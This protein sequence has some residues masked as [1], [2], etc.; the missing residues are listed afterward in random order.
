MEGFRVMRMID[1]VRESDVV[2]TTTGGLNVVGAAHLD[3]IKDQCILS[4]VGHFNKEIDIPALRAAAAA[5]RVVRPDVEEFTLPGGRRVYLLANGELV[6]IAVGQGHPAEIMDMTFA[7]QSLAPNYL[8]ARR[9]TLEPRFYPMPRELD[10][11]VAQ[12]KLDTLGIRI[13]ELTDEQKRYSDYY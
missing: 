5:A 12:M 11:Q 3:A 10:E 7:L 2:I 9:G 6:N 4:N 13:D 1:A 8:L